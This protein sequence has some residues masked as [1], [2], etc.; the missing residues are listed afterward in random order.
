MCSCDRPRGYVC[1]ACSGRRAARAVEEINRFRLRFL[2]DEGDAPSPS[3]WPTANRVRHF[4]ADGANAPPAP[5][6]YVARI[7][8]GRD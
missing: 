5:A 4:D 1:D 8:A 2:A 7:R 6:D 3:G